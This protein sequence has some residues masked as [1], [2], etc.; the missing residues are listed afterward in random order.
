M[1][2]AEAL[3]ALGVRGK[4]PL[5]RAPNKKNARRGGCGGVAQP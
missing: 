2:A 4:S 1:S 3:E 5:K